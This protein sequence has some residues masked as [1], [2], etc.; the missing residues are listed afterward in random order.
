[1]SKKTQ[2]QEKIGKI[3]AYIGAF[4]T[5]V[6]LIVGI[7]GT[8]EIKGW[9]STNERIKQAKSALSLPDDV[10]DEYSQCYKEPI[11]WDCS[12]IM[13][14]EKSVEISMGKVC[15][16]GGHWG[17]ASPMLT[18]E[19]LNI[20]IKPGQT[21]DWKGSLSPSTSKCTQATAI[22]R[23]ENLDEYLHQ[24]KD[25]E[26]SMDVVRP[27]IAQGTNKFENLT[28]PSVLETRVYIV[29][30]EEFKILSSNF[31]ARWEDVGDAFGT[32]AFTIAIPSGFLVLFFIAWKNEKKKKTRRNRTRNTLKWL[33]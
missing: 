16:I 7:K 6:W 14:K 5:F 2:N 19:D 22:L 27:V 29:T 32:L 18:P 1:M 17:G 13:T 11:N 10:I 23:T 28:S 4:I 9:V 21:K 12:I 33:K 30:P 20:K 25:I 15:G 3:I 8:F 24:Y 26:I 31:Y